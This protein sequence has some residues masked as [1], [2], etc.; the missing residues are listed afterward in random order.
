MYSN[1]ESGEDF[2]NYVS[3]GDVISSK[4]IKDLDGILYEKVKTDIIAS[5]DEFYD[6]RLDPDLMECTIAIA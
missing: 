2:F 5:F 1:F 3:K 6:Q 4:I